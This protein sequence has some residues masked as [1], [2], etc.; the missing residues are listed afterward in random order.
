M[1]QQLPTSEEN[2]VVVTTKT[3]LTKEKKAQIIES[4]GFDK[5]STLDHDLGVTLEQNEIVFNIGS[6]PDLKD[7]Y[8]VYSWR[9]IYEIYNLE[10]ESV[11]VAI[12]GDFNVG[13][14]YL[15][16][17]SQIFSF[18]PISFINVFRQSY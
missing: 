2:P 14:S 4:F 9:P 10:T 18:L 13:K 11:V 16:V 12:F 17:R 5:E 3:P 1:Q 8:K 15:Q 6:I 7:G